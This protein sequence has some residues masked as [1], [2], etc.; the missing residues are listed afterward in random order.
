MYKQ[1][2]KCQ[3]RILLAETFDNQNRTARTEV[4]LYN[5]NEEAVLVLLYAD[6]KKYQGYLCLIIDFGCNKLARYETCKSNN[7]VL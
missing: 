7:S 2:E 6:M 1:I 3:N 4:K 5:S